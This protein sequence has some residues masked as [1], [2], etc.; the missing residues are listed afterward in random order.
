MTAA[1]AAAARGLRQASGVV[2]LSVLLDSATEH[3]RARFRN[4]AML[5]PLAASGMTLLASFRNSHQI[6]R[7]R[8]AARDA[9][10]GCAVLAGLAGGGFHAYNVGKRTGGMAWQNLF[11]GAPIG[12]PFALLLAGLL[13]AAADRV[14]GATGTAAPQ[15]LG[16]DAGRV[17]A[18]LTS[19]GLMGTVG[20]VWLLHFRGA[21]HNPV[22][23][24]PVGLPPVGAALL[25]RAAAAPRGP[26]LL[27]RLWLRLTVILGIAG[28]GFHA[29]GVQRNMGGW[30]NWRQNLLVGPPLPAPPSFSGL[31]MAGLA[32]LRLLE[33]GTDGAGT[34]HRAP[35]RRGLR[36]WRVP[37]L[38]S[39]APAQRLLAR[40]DG[41]RVGVG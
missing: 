22:M 36:R 25:A 32:A 1:T 34:H 30:A 37:G 20:E 41:R 35:G 18:G 13:G 3:Y 11:Y 4:P 33:A 24:L 10:F 12:A 9:V 19:L 39:V 16:H 15:L 29:W 23:F 5:V 17:L 21:F 27:A 8:T 7:G 40:Q 6:P 26:H 14:Q 31:A 28:V 2:A 38:A